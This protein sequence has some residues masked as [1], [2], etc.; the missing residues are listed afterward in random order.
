MTNTNI[1]DLL[2]LKTAQCYLTMTQKKSLWH[3]E[4]SVR[5]ISFKLNKILFILFY[6]SRLNK[7][8][9]TTKLRGE[10]VG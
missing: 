4:N 2:T 8:Q 5:K 7:C 9:S 6:L 3:G 1:I 10:L